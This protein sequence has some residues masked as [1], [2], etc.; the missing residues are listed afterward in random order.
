MKA[1]YVLWGYPHLSESY[2]RNEIEWVTAQGVQVEVR[3]EW[4]SFAPHPTDVPVHRRVPLEEVIERFKPDL[5]Q[6]HWLTYAARMLNRLWGFGLPVFIRGHS[7]DFSPSGAM[8]LANDTAIARIFLFPHFADEVRHKKV[9]PLPACYP[10]ALFKPSP[11]KDR[12]LVV[13]VATALLSKNLNL[14]FNLA[15]SL[16]QLRFT[17]AVV[18]SH[19]APADMA[20][21]IRLNRAMGSPVTMEYNLPREKISELLGRAGLYVHTH[22]NDHHRF[23][24][25]MGVVEALGSGCVTLVPQQRTPIPFDGAC[26]MYTDEL[27]ASQILRE[28]LGWRDRWLEAQAETRRMA[29]R[30]TCDQVLPSVL[31]EWQKCCR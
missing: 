11:L 21:F 29:E 20:H 25:P 5:I 18:K 3:C 19:G 14:F 7:F 10:A 15:K 30:L 28:T 2:I 4:E 23:G 17:L 16:P 6:V 22:S 24:M 8:E 12:Q 13:R 1:L 26:E 9:V 31:A 27:H